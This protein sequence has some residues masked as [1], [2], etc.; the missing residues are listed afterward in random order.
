MTINEAKRIPI[1]CFFPNLGMK[2][3][4]ESSGKWD[5]YLHPCGAKI[6][7][8][9]YPYSSK[10]FFGYE[11]L[12][13]GKGGSIIDLLMD[14]EC[15]SLS[16][17]VAY[18]C[19]EQE[20][21]KIEYKPD[22]MPQKEAPPTLASLLER[23][24][25]LKQ[26]LTHLVARA[27]VVDNFLDFRGIS[28]AMQQKWK[29]K[30][31]KCSWTVPFFDLFEGKWLIRSYLEHGIGD[32]KKKFAK[33][34]RG[35]ALS[36]IPFRKGLPKSVAY[37]FESPID[38][39]SFA[40][41]FDAQLEAKEK[42]IFLLSTGGRMG[43]STLAQKLTSLDIDELWLGFDHDQAGEKM[44]LEVQEAVP[45]AK[46]IPKKMYQGVKDWNERLVGGKTKG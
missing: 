6:L 29:Q 9:K 11:N 22:R 4:K 39:L 10:G 20:R 44:A 18:V 5:I 45:L 8:C 30:A 41:L 32:P 3:T 19:A 16:Q 42:N 36:I 2:K 15:M 12:G 38:A 26:E 23:E 14:L 24:K 1:S 7:A 27:H 37:M 28:Q 34:T 40:Q 31:K 33:G 17:A 25:K 21:P 43:F 46:Q 13:T 35:G